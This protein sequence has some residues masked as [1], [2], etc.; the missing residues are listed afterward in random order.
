MIGTKAGVFD[1]AGLAVAFSTLFIGEFTSIVVVRDQV[2]RR[3]PG[4]FQSVT[5]RLPVGFQ[6]FA[7][8]ML[9]DM[10]GQHSIGKFVFDLR[11][12]DIVR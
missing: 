6:D 12:L 1:L 3:L 9:V 8:A 5:K 2:T 11:R 7:P 10:N 4:G